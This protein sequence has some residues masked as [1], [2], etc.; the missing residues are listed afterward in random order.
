M[1]F[2][3]KLKKNNKIIVKDDIEN[4]NSNSTSLVEMNNYMLSD[5]RKEFLSTN[6]YSISLACV[7]KISP[8]AIPTAN[9]IKKI[10]GKKAANSS[11]TLYRI[12]NLG[13]NDTLKAMKNGKTF[14]GAIKKSDGSSVMAKLQETNTNG[15]LALDP[16]IMMMS[17][18]LSGIESELGE[19]KELNKKIFSFLEEEKEA[20]IESDLEI[21][22]RAIEEFKFNLNDE[23]YIAN[24]HQQ[25]MDIKRTANKNMLFYEKQIKDT[26]SK[27]SFLVMNSGMNSLLEDI[28]K[29]L[30][31]YRLSLYIYSFSTLI[32]ILL[33][34]NYQSDYLLKKTNELNI[35]DEKYTNTFNNALEYVKKNANKLL[36]G[37]VLSGL[38]DA[39]KAISNL[40][41]KMNIKNADNWL[42]EKGNNLK[43][44]SKNIKESFSNKLEEIKESNTKPFIN[45]IEN[46]NNIYNKTKEVYFDDKNIYL[47]MNK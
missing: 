31:Y 7:S 44:N 23:K 24:N 33:I 10:T 46:I 43:Q 3:N 9:A 40:A 35:L 5:V 36:E 30:K 19:I 22:N 8:I 20:E 11:N 17:I 13:V 45:Q 15:V 27:E 41:K 21:L 28:E 2:F 34:G 38:G 14:W 29:K 47:E 4:V 1:G 26:L 16:T 18:A 42:N 6:C 25:I 37:N 39:G 12:T 32:E